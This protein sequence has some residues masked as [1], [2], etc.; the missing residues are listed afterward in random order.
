[1]SSAW[2]RRAAWVGGSLALAG[3]AIA[4]AAQEDHHTASRTAADY[5]VAVVLPLALGWAAYA[6]FVKLSGSAGPLWSPW[7]LACAWVFALLF[8]GTAHRSASGN[9][10]QTALE[11]VG[12]APASYF[13][14]LPRGLSAVPDPQGETQFRDGMRAAGAQ[15]DLAV[16]QVTRRGH[17]VAEAVVFDAGDQ[18]DDVLRGMLDRAGG[19]GASPPRPVRLGE[20]QGKLMTLTSNGRTVVIVVGFI[21]CSGAFVGGAKEGDVRQVATA[22]LS[23]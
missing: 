4:G 11:C 20:A 9:R 3:L 23:P 21:G 14:S 17:T 16:R 8:L 19:R 13:A 2:Q 1:M 15:V 5:T 10:A 22:L 18:R 7:V 12:P 6:L